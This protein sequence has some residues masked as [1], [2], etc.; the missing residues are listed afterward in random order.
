MNSVSITV[1][2]LWIPQCPV[3]EACDT[4]GRAHARPAE[5]KLHPL[6][7]FAQ[8]HGEGIQRN[9]GGDPQVLI[10]HRGISGVKQS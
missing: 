10:T 8:T 6:A 9:T 2:R 1:I 4:V 5:N 3:I 7:D